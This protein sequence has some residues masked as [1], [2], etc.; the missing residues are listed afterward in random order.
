M[1]ATQKL[2]RFGVFE[3]NVDNEELFKSA[4]PVKLPPQPLKLLVLLASRAGQVVIRNEIQEQLWVGETFVDFEHGVNKCINQIRTALGDN[5]DNPVYVETLPRRG[6]RFVAPVV[7]KSIPAPLPKVIESD[8]G[9]R[10]RLPVLIVG[11]T[12]TATATAAVAAASEP[13]IVPDARAAIEPTTDAA[14]AQKIRFRWS[15]T[16]IATIGTVVLLVAAAGGGLYWR[17][18]ARKI[19]VLTDKDTIVLADFENK[20]GDPVFDDTLKQGLTI[21]LKQSP[22]LELISQGKVNQTLKLMERPA[23]RILTPDVAREVCQR[24][25]SK[26]MLTGSIV[27]LGSQYVIGLKAVNCNTEDVLAEAQEQAAS[28]ESVLKALDAVAISL[29]S[30]LGESLSSLQKYATPLAEVTTPSLEALQAYTRATRAVDEGDYQAAIGLS[31]KAIDLDPSFA[32]AYVNL[33]VSYGDLAQEDRAVRCLRKAYLLR[34]RVSQ[35]ERFEIS[36]IYANDVTGNV[37][38]SRGAYELWEQVYPND[39]VPPTHLGN[40]YASLGDYDK[41]LAAFK[42]VLKMNPGSGLSYANLAAIYELVDHPDEVKR[43]AREAWASHLDHPAIHSALYQVAF[44][45]HDL[46][47]TKREGAI[48][49]GKQGWQDQILDFDSDTAAYTGHLSKARELTRD[50]V[51]LAELA[52]ANDSAACYKAAEAVREALVGNLGLAKRAARA[53][54]GLSDGRDA[55]AISAV[56]LALAGDAVPAKR[57]TDDLMRRFPEDT[58]VQFNFLPVIRAA[59]ALSNGSPTKALEALAPAAPYELGTIQGSATFE[60]YPIYLR[61]Q[62]YL[63]AH[64]GSAAGTEFQKVLDHPGLVLNE[65]IAAQ[66]RL[67]LARAYALSGDPTRAKAAY[68]DFLTLWKDADPDVPILIQAKAEYAVLR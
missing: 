12:R 37:V 58:I 7:S 3:L 29:R 39:P 15:R 52:K 14:P 40:A 34:D 5:A 18:R 17:A 1:S 32:L 62:A 59:T 35:R 64:Q 20:T 9:E 23:D 45:Q 67:G 4:R 21:Q 38:A 63:A 61:G 31:Q 41:A 43:T 55:V 30:K 16:R 27:S 22:F 57:T 56:A 10:G 47:T 66:A 8:S 53:A 42:R 6:Y 33:G 68:Q 49:M 54:L 25:G 46:S 11:R 26:A 44:L 48:L 60:L 28:K 51:H 13:S 19:P 65:P 50:A 36:A 24:T 2:L